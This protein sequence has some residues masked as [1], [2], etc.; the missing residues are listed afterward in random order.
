MSGPCY[1]NRIIC[2]HA[3]AVLPQ[4]VGSSRP[5]TPHIRSSGQQISSPAHS[6]LSTH[7]ANVIEETERIRVETNSRRTTIEYPCSYKLLA[8]P[9]FIMVSRSRELPSRIG[10]SVGR[11][12]GTTI[13]TPGPMPHRV[14]SSGHCALLTKV[15]TNYSHVSMRR[16][17]NCRHNA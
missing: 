15:I 8:G 13:E 16:N 14:M 11:L 6:A 12:G 3:N 7:S 17:L 4:A 9:S 10:L 1:I 2:T 5:G